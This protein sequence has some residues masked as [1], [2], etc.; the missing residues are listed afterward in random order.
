MRR[1]TYFIIAGLAVILTAFGFSITNS[2]AA[3]A[4]LPAETSSLHA[5]VGDD[6]ACLSCHQNPEFTT[7]VGNLQKSEQFVL[8]VNPDEYN[9]SVHGQMGIT[10]IECHI[11]FKPEMGHGKSFISRREV[12]I[13]MN[14]TCGNC[15]KKQ[16]EKQKDSVHSQMIAFGKYEA[17]TCTDCHTAHAVKRMKDPKTGLLY[18]ETRVWIPGTCN[19]C[20]STI[21]EKYRNSV[22]GEALL[23]DQNPDVPTCIDC[24]GV[25]NILNPT[26][27]KFRLASPT[28]CAKC[29]TDPKR[30]DKYGISTE[31]MNTYVADFHG[32]TVS[33]FEQVSP[34]APTNKPVCYDCHGV[35]DITRV[36]DPKKGLEIKA[37]L[38]IKCQKCHPDAN[39]N[40][41]DAWMSHYI[42]STDKYPIV[43]YIN[44]FYKFLIPGVLVPM[45]VLV[46]LDFSR[47]TINRF[48]KPE[49]VTPPIS[50]KTDKKAADTEVK[51]D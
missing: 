9:H 3:K 41:P 30:M 14:E 24:H 21:V 46:L 10:C 40:F 23:N 35:H 7:N 31:V 34:D 28:M 1:R 37:N 6:A 38:L 20:H 2:K 16:A 44:L 29:H 17:A 22:H 12:T 18:P 5:P 11:D 4:E 50:E 47:A 45:G 42:P 32:T 43:Y 13:K 51:H 49:K 39:T 19:Q 8:F 27:D 26:T 33:I 25:H 15:H 48:K 36:D